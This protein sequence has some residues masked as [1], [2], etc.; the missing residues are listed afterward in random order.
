[1]FIVCSSEKSTA[2]TLDKSVNDLGKEYDFDD[3]VDFYE[4]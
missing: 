3:E 4:R 2:C 1:M